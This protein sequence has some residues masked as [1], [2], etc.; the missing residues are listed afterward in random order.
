MRVRCQSEDDVV[1]AAGFDELEE[2]LDDDFDSDDDCDDFD[3][4]SDDFDSDVLESEPDEASDDV[5]EESDD[6]G[7]LELLVLPRLS[8]LKK[9]LPLKVTPTGWNT[10]LTAIMRPVSGCLYLVRVLSAKDCWTSMVSPEST[11]LY[12]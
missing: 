2:L 11:N 6:P 9:P 5:L 7:A 12:T 10:F 3:D 4:D 8:F 1:A